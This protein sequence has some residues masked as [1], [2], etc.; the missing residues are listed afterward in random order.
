M[1]ALPPLVWPLGAAVEALDELAAENQRLSALTA[2]QSELAATQVLLSSSHLDLD[3]FMETLVARLAALVGAQGASVEIADGE[4]LELRAGCGSQSAAVGERS[5]AR[6]CLSGL[7]LRQGRSLSCDDARADA[8]LSE[9]ERGAGALMVAPLYC[10]G[11]AVGAL[12]A[13]FERARS[14]TEADL[15]TLAVMAGFAG[16]AIGR[17]LQME[18]A[19]KLLIERSLALAQLAEAKREIERER[20]LISEQE[21][22]TRLILETTQDAFV[23]S[24]QDGRVTDWNKAAER[25]FGWARAEALGRDLVELI[26]PKG[27]REE[28][29]SQREL[30]LKEGSSPLFSQRHRQMLERKGGGEFPAE[31][32]VR[33]LKTSIGW[34]FCAFLQD[35]SE[36]AK[37]EGEMRRQARSDQL[38]GLPNRLA[39]EDRMRLAMERSRRSKKPMALMYLDVDFFKSINDTLG[40]LAGDEALKGLALAAR[41]RMRESDTLARLGGDEFAAIFEELGSFSDACGV[42]Q[43]IVA[44]ARE[45]VLI[46]GETLPMSVS[47][48]VSFYT[49]DAV[50][51]EE[52]IDRADKALYE[53]KR[54][55]RNGF[56]VSHID[57]E[58]AQAEGCSAPA[59]VAP[60]TAEALAR[61]ASKEVDDK[62][63]GG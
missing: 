27:D 57:L 21:R 13:V 48:G 28:V 30:F 1:A 35:I 60:G 24:G 23:V 16:E 49:G 52:L 51:E 39:F 56:R 22:R 34:E 58:R 43:K 59:L 7:S 32:S 62:K 2:R 18:Q 53:V 8:R 10:A 31:L 44:A 29:R 37:A 5:K 41:S 25:M 15:E 20:D 46:R 14:I 26:I 54:A 45:G 38:T 36:R 42:A 3:E 33:G 19:E 4:E 47:C 50:S 12:T 61:R 6:G 11:S 17:Q 40:H 55:G 9:R 63:P